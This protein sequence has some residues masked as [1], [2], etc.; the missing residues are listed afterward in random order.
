MLTRA[1]CMRHT[2]KVNAAGMCSTHYR[3]VCSTEACNNKAYAR[4]VCAKH[5]AYANKPAAVDGTLQTWAGGLQGALAQMLERRICSVDGCTNRSKSKGLKCSKRPP[6]GLPPAPVIPATALPHVCT[7]NGCTKDARRNEK[8]VYFSPCL[9]R[10]A[11]L[12]NSMSKS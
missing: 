1:M 5:G 2:L 6:P 7:V 8:K 12:G 3:K 10:S 11:S 9:Y 4:G